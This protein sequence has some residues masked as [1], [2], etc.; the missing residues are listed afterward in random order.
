[1]QVVDRVGEPLGPALPSFEALVLLELHQRCVVF[2][3][4]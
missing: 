3:S 1:V 4:C 2:L